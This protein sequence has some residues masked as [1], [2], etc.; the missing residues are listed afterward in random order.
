[1]DRYNVLTSWAAWR[2]FLIGNLFA[3]LFL[4]SGIARDEIIQA[5]ENVQGGSAYE[6]KKAGAF[7]DFLTRFDSRD[8]AR[9]DVAVLVLIMSALYL[10]L[11][12]IAPTL[13]PTDY[14]WWIGSWILVALSL[15]GLAWSAVQQRFMKWPESKEEYER[16]LDLLRTIGVTAKEPLGFGGLSVVFLLLL[17]DAAMISIVAVDYAADLPRNLQLFGGLALGIVFALGLLWLTHLTGEQTFRAMH[18]DRLIKQIRS[19]MAN[20]EN[21]KTSAFLAKIKTFGF[22]FDISEKT[23]F[24]R[25]GFL[26]L[27]LCLI[28][29]VVGLATYARYNQNQNILFEQISS[30]LGQGWGTSRD[31]PSP[32]V[33][34]AHDENIKI[35]SNQ[36]IEAQQ[37]AMI[38]GISLLAIVFI[39]VQAFAINIGYRH[40]FALDG[41]ED[42][43]AYEKV[44][45][46]RLQN[47]HDALGKADLTGSQQLVMNK[48]QTFFDS[49]YA[50]LKDQAHRESRMDIAESLRERLAFNFASYTVK[51]FKNINPTQEGSPE[52]TGL[53]SAGKQ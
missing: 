46:Y 3:R 7:H 20:S 35:L 28:A 33:A 27:T 40:S 13:M 24:R 45:Q 37:K 29:L 53:S 19:E 44:R 26:T 25:Y 47:I 21:H 38:A 43:L 17:V 50:A 49:Y 1:M 18:H 52:K 16:N 4:F 8:F 22:P 42:R 2:I 39:I 6:R 51:R 31:I 36:T 30:S 32:D 9:N 34:K 14:G 41:G 23:F 15:S 5:K 11:Y 10:A 48:A 12:S